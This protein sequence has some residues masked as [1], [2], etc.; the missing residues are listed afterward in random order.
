MTT[1]EDRIRTVLASQAEAMD[2]PDAGPVEQLARVT[3]L[4]TQRRR[5]RLFLV[6]AVA[7][8]VVAAGVALANRGTDDT[9]ANTP[10]AASTFRFETPTVLLEA[11]SVEVTVAHQVFVPPAD[12]EVAGDPGTPNEYT[13]LEL[14]WHQHNVEQ[15]IYIYFTSDGTNWWANEIRTYDGNSNAEWIEQQ[16]E[17]FKSALGSAYVGDLNLPNL[18]IHNMHLEVFRRPSSCEN[19]TGPLALVANFPTIDS[20]AG[21]YG[22]TL[23]VIDTATCTPVPVSAFT[24]EYTSDNPAV[25]ELATEQLN[26]PDC[27]P[28]LTRVDVDLVSPGATTIH[29]VAR[30]QV[31]N[32]V[33]TADMHVTVRPNDATNTIDTGPPPPSVVPEM[34]TLP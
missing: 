22:A 29:A 28:N 20:P 32:V 2:A 24:F 25:A 3:E 21:G 14:T 16:G 30:D 9:V 33:G 15:R 13:T 10:A 17:F 34:S 31:G 23:S 11:E 12:V 18:K 1:L 6:A 19:P 5:P 26:V 27:P 7:G 4:Q 8:L